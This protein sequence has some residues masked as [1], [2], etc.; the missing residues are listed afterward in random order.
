[1]TCQDHYIHVDQDGVP[2]TVGNFN[3]NDIVRLVSAVMQVMSE[4]KTN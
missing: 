4:G 2:Y 3:L 1:M